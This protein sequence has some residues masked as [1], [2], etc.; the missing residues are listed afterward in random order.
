MHSLGNSAGGQLAFL[1]WPMS[2]EGDPALLRDGLLGFPEFWVEEGFS[3][4][5]AFPSV[6][7]GYPFVQVRH[8]VMS[9]EDGLECG[10]RLRDVIA[11][12]HA[13]RMDLDSWSRNNQI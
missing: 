2:I 1:G 8:Q 13:R 3:H 12:V 11:M 10:R 9:I 5:Q 6:L 7:F 4:G